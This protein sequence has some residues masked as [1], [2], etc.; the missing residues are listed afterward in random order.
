VRI[1]LLSARQLRNGGGHFAVIGVASSFLLAVHE[2]LAVYDDL[3]PP[4]P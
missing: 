1:Q 2:M 3:K 4:A